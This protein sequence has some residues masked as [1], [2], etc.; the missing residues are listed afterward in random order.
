MAL[1]AVNGYFEDLEI[2]QEAYSIIKVQKFEP[3]PL[4]RSTYEDFDPV[5]HLEVIEHT[6]DKVEEDQDLNAEEDENANKVDRIKVMDL[7]RIWLRI[8]P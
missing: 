3:P 1:F 6:E 4:G 7:N 5:V 2:P 8:K